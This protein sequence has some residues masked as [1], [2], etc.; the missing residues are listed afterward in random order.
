MGWGCRS[1]PCGVGA[2]YEQ[3][4]ARGQHGKEHNK[5]LRQVNHS[6]CESV[7]KS[8]AKTKGEHGC[9]AL[10]PESY[11]AST[12]ERGS[13]APFLCVDRSGISVVASLNERNLE[14]AS[15]QPTDDVP[16]TCTCKTVIASR[17]E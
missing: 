1:D 13:D 7:E 3:V 16:S 5:N 17:E 4:S 12:H 14:L 15:C 9:P 8:Y 11:E 10:P 6:I 2:S